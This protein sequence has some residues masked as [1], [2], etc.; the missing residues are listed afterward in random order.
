MLPQHVFIDISDGQFWALARL[1]SVFRRL[2]LL[3]RYKRHIRAFVT[4]KPR[5]IL[6]CPPTHSF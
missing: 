6:F 5:R 3:T 4:E 1:D 2:M